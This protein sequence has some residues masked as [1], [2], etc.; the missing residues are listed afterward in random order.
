MRSWA[1]P[2]KTSIFKRRRVSSMRALPTMAPNRAWGA[3]SHASRTRNRTISEQFPGDEASSESVPSPKQGSRRFGTHLRHH[4]LLFGFVQPAFLL[5]NGSTA[6]LL[7]APC[8]FCN[9][10]FVLFFVLLQVFLGAP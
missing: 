9:F 8:D 1:R 10:G 7:Q 3:Q 5:E 6:P 4:V 2:S